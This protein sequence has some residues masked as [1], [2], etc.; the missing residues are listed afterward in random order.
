[1][2]IILGNITDRENSHEDYYAHLLPQRTHQVTE[3]MSVK[4]NVEQL[5]NYF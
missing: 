4:I 2:T 1:M 5:L 3:K